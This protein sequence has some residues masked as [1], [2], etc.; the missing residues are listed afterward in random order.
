M[1]QINSHMSPDQL[2]DISWYRGLSLELAEIAQNCSNNPPK[3][4][5]DDFYNRS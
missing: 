4:E 5:E 2:P 3:V 1:N